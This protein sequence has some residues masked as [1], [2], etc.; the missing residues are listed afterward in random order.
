MY[1]KYQSFVRLFLSGLVVI[2][3]S[4]PGQSQ[5]GGRVPHVLFLITDDPLNYDAQINIPPFADSLR[6]SGL[7][8]TTV[9]KG[10]GKHE[11]F[12]FEGLEKAIDQADVLVVYFR[13][14]ALSHAQME[15]VKT[16]IRSGKPVVGI[17]SA[18]HGFSVRGKM[19]E[20]GY[21]SW[22]G[23]CSD[24]L[25]HEYKGHDSDEL[26]AL[27]EVK[28]ENSAHPILQGVET[29]PWKSGGGVYR[30]SPLIDPKAVVLLTSSNPAVKEPAAWVREND[31]GG[32]VFYTS[33][34]YPT[35]FGHA[36]F[37]TLIVNVF[38]WAAH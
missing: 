38:K 1:L 33:L 2:L 29:M 17:R 7:F 35:D 12:H 18:N 10:H 3:L 13:R 15:K 27:I 14:L 25:G 21:E 32:K 20:R 22:W 30:V 36:Q 19:A 8:T 9:L 5:V 28:P 26:G 34:G 4:S 6:K 11:A 16:Y 23:F 31:F 37:R 24:I